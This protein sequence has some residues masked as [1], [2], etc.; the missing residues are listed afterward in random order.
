[1][2]RHGAGAEQLAKAAAD[3]RLRVHLIGK[4]QARSDVVEIAVVLRTVVA[5]HAHEAQAALQVRHRTGERRGDGRVK[6]AH[7]VVAFGARRVEVIANAQVE[8]QLA[9]DAPIILNVEG[10]IEALA[11]DVF[12]VL[13]E[14]AARA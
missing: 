6:P 13:I 14:I 2:A 12:P 8:R 5:I 3:G 10:M 9:G 4:A 1:M 7:T 11:G